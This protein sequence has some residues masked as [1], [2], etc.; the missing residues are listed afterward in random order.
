MSA[1]LPDAVAADAVL[2]F[3]V[4]TPVTIRPQRADDG[5]L[6]TEFVRGLSPAARYQRFHMTLT[7]VSAALLERLTRI[8]PPRELA[9]LAT[10][11]SGPR[12]IVLAEA[13]YGDADDGSDARDF[14]L[15]VGDAWQRVGIGARLLR[16]LMRRAARFGVRRLAGDV[17]VANQPM[18]ALARRFGFSLRR[19]PADARLVRVDRTLDDVD[20]TL[21]VPG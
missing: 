11:G 3:A 5:A 19:H 20:W 7:D 16:E 8:A 21:E 17:L 9:L 18:L 13:R 15:A 6:L 10:L 14:A 12:E 2:R 4:A 1:R